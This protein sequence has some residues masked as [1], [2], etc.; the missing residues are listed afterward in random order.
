MLMTG[1]WV[2]S[3]FNYYFIQFYMKYVPGD[4]FINNSASC[5][6]EL[7][8]DLLSCLFVFKIGI[9][10]SFFGAFLIAAI[11][12]VCMQFSDVHGDFIA[13]FVLMTKFGI[14]FAFNCTY[15]ATP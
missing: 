5:L 4:I 15:L 8:A 2:T 7:A 9:K 10:K 3:S 1:V 14:S 11:G 6:A 12:A 13:V